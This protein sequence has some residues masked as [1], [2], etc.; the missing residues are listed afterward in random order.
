MVLPGR[1]QQRRL[2]HLDVGRAQL[3]DAAEEV[4]GRK[5]YHATTLKEVADLA[6]FSVGSVYSYFEN[7]D[8]LYAHVFLR[9]GI[10]MVAAMRQAVEGGATPVDQLHRLVDAQ[11]GFFRAHPHFGR[12]YLRTAI[13]DL[14]ALRTDLDTTQMATL[15]EAWALQTDLFARGQRAG[16]LRDGDPFALARLLSGIV[17]AFQATDPLVMGTGTAPGPATTGPTAALA[18]LHAVVEDGFHR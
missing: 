5:G 10:E 15:R 3:L 18:L 12:L 11:V 8:D 16:E 7:K 9:R 1:R 2:H 14:P 17:S 13:T 6:E 4:F